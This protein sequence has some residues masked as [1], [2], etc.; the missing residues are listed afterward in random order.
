MLCLLIVACT[1]FLV[2]RVLYCPPAGRGS[3]GLGCDCKQA[4][5][6]HRPGELTANCICPKSCAKHTCGKCLCAQPNI[7]S[8]ALVECLD[9]RYNAI[10]QV[11]TS[12]VI[13]LQNDQRLANSGEQAAGGAAPFAR[14]PLSSRRYHMHCLS[15]ED[16][17]LVRILL[18]RWCI[19]VLPACAYSMLTDLA[20]HAA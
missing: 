5:R 19:L 7:C 11:C 3:T 8:H 16:R 6:Q 1:T 12:G 18:G 10:L 13:P 14:S 4:Q 9:T 20:A 17:V 2:F 15:E